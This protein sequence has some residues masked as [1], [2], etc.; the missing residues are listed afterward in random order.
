MVQ[1]QLTP[2]TYRLTFKAFS[3]ITHFNFLDM[4]IMTVTM[5]VVF[6]GKLTSKLKKI[7]LA[8]IVWI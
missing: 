5:D 7:M 8:T 6:D 2:K 3:K 1:A 4:K